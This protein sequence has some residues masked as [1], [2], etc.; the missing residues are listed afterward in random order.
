[1]SLIIDACK[2]KNASLESFQALLNSGDFDIDRQEPQTGHTAL[3][4]AI[5]FRNE[6]LALDLLTRGASTVDH[7]NADG[8]TLLM[9]AVGGNLKAAAW[10]LALRVTDLEVSDRNGWTALSCACWFSC[11][12]IVQMLLGRGA[13]VLTKS[14][15]GRSVFHQAVMAGRLATA[16][17]LL[18][19]F[20]VF[21][22][23]ARDAQSNQALHLVAVSG[24]AEAAQWLIIRGA[25]IEA[26]GT[27]CR[28]PLMEASA[29]GKIDVARVLLRA[30]VSGYIYIYIY[31]YDV[32][33]RFV[34]IF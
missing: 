1:M 6:D 8:K 32:L 21:S 23:H 33:G 10:E 19:Q 16:E 17:F 24:K 9:R 30:G 15:L 28:T 29:G 25:E 12:E 11:L 14:T 20:T 34:I 13:S 31:I 27:F 5:D 22:V 2:T 3:S 7:P 4:V 18:A 26:M